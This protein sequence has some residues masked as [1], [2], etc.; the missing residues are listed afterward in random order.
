MAALALLVTACT[1][2]PTSRTPSGDSGVAPA[3]VQRTLVMVVRT[4]GESIAGKTLTNPGTNVIPAGP[5]NA[6]L[7]YRDRAEVPQPYQAEALP[8][9]NTDSWRVMPDGRMETIYRL[10]PNLTWHDHTPLTA[11]DF[12]FAYRVYSVPEVSYSAISSPMNKIEE[13]VGLD[14]R[15]MLIRW[16]Q[17]YAEAG[18]LVMGDLQALPRHILEQPF[19]QLS[20]EQFVAH[21]Y[22][23]LEYVGSGPYRVV[24]WDRNVFLESE[25]FDGHVL[26]RPKID[27][28]RVVPIPD[29]NVVL[30]NMLAG[31][32]H[33]AVA[34][35]M[36]F[37]QGWTLKREW[38]A[39]GGG[40]VP[41][42]PGGARRTENQVHPERA[43]PRFMMDVRVRRALAHTTNRQAVNDAV[44][45]GT[46]I[47]AHTMLSPNVAYFADV[48]RVL[49]KYPYDPRRAEQ[50][51]NEAGLAK[52]SDGFYVGPV[53]ERLEWEIL[54]LSGPQNESIQAVLADTWRRTGFNMRESVFPVA[55]VSDRE[56]R[57]RFS[58]MFTTDGGSLDG[59][60]AA[61]I[62]TAQNRWSG[63]N[64]GSWSNAEYDRLVASWES[65]LDRNQRNGYMVQMAKLYSEELGSTPLFYHLTVTP[66]AIGLKGVTEGVYDI[67]NWFWES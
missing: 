29:P 55:M 11:H 64:R 53:G 4:E 50:L 18:E 62:P 59:M 49:M 5:F 38:D 10:K 58:T 33:V 3:G 21:P 46:G 16:K 26:G 8:Q 45:E 6:G 56:A 39:R 19:Q 67:H 12:A 47:D 34:N 20:S 9:L 51:M 43:S 37:Q 44:F 35:A 57:A 61:G 14:D 22:W 17:P 52:G 27:R 2:A 23:T 1:A 42:N 7:V 32:T 60:N 65:T 48:D 63:S 25:A 36:P 24:R 15:T 40:S 66:H 28:L 31:E 54:C 41:I 13:V 30:A